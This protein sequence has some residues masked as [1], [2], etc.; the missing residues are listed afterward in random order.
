MKLSDISPLSNENGLCVGG[1]YFYHNYKDTEPYT[2][3]LKIL[4]QNPSEYLYVKLPISETIKNKA[5]ILK[6]KC[7]DSAVNMVEVSFTDLHID[8][9]T[10]RDTKTGHTITRYNASAKNFEIVEE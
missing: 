7:I 2:Y 3:A 6:Q 5:L 9:Y 10:Y 8:S 1:R 4:T